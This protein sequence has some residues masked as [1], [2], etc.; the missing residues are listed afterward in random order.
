MV[1]K[2]KD[3]SR[4]IDHEDFREG[5]IGAFVRVTYHRQY[6]VAII[7]DFKQ[8]I[9]SYRLNQIDT[10]WQIVLRNMGQ[11]KQFKLNMISDGNVEQAEFEKMRKDNSGYNLTQD[12]LTKK[13]EE[14]AEA[15]RFQYDQDTMTRL[16]NI[17]VFERIR[18]G[19]FKGLNLT[20]SKLALQGEIALAENQLAEAEEAESRGEAAE[21]RDR[22]IEL[23][24]LYVR[25]EK[26]LTEDSQGI[27]NRERKMG[28]N[29]KK[30]GE[31]EEWL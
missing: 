21:L 7:E 9:E 15:N 10:K 19:N 25:V 12:Y 20:D 23:R 16:V 26:R 2:R 1:L 6:V 17:R 31:L 27:A 28:A 18:A 13:M 14:I 5:L 4:W 22:V 29:L 30:V 3:F 11:L 24:A 8:G